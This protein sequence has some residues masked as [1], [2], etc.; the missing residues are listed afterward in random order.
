MGITSSV[1]AITIAPGVKRMPQEPSGP[2]R[3]SSRYTTRP[4]T[5][6]GRP[7]RAFITTITARRPGKLATATA[8]PSGSP[9]AQ[10]STAEARLTPMERTTMR[11]NSAS[12]PAM[13]CRASPKLAN[14][15]N[16]QNFCK[17]AEIPQTAALE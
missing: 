11:R 1:C 5:T 12:P 9:I 8:A 10:A 7:S 16:I 17:K 13:S 15:S 14:I 6:E 3:E 2:A 4:T